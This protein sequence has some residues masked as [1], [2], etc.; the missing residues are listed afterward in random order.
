MNAQALAERTDDTPAFVALTPN[1]VMDMI[2]QAVAAGQPLDVI[3]EL[4]DMAKELAADEASRAFKAA[5]AAFKAEA[6]TIV[7]NRLVTD[8]PLKGKRY[9]ELFSF[10]DAVT[11]ALSK[12]GLSASWDI[13]KDDKDWISVACTV[14]HALGGGKTVTM[15]APPDTGGAKNVIQARASAVTYLERI[16]LKAACGLAEQGDDDD[17]AATGSPVTID[18]K[19]LAKLRGL[20]DEVGGDIA[21]LCAHFKIEALPD[22]P[23]SKLAEAIGI[24]ELRRGAKK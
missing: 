11:P 1:P 19:Q 15:G 16:T 2:R 6:T 8:G 21:K 20:I 14:E 23:I 17:G 4:K 5:F 7:R 3:R 12:H 18:D 22:L 24:V 9:A 10:V 13:V